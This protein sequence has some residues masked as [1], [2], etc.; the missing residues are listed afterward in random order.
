MHMT[1]LLGG[2]LAAPLAALSMSRSLWLPFAL[3]LVSCLIQLGIAFAITEDERNSPVPENSHSSSDSIDGDEAGPLLSIIPSIQEHQTY[4]SLDFR[5]AKEKLLKILSIPQI[6]ICLVIFPL[7]RAGFQSQPFIYQYAS[8][9]FNLKLQQTP[10][11]GA[12]R[13]GSSVI[14]VGAVLP[15]LTNFLRKTG[16][17]K[18]AID[19][20]VLRGTALVLTMTSFG[21]WAASN[22]TLYSLGKPSLTERG[23]WANVREAVVL[24]GFGEGLE[25]ALLGHSSSLIDKTQGS[26]LFSAIVSMESFSRII[27]AS[28]MAKLYSVNRDSDGKPTGLPFLVSSV[29]L[30][31]CSKTRYDHF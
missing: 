16:L 15:I 11:F 4:P 19:L 27:A 20:G 25:P 1:S 31:N 3:A 29:S 9:R 26:Q 24:I 8:E 5:S 21:I 6:V 30:T 13:S 7:K 17:Q 28:V 18:N 23:V 22:T 12:A 10:W 14:V 2:A